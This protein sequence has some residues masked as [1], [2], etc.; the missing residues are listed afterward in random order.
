M[1]F[2]YKKYRLGVIRP[3]I[4]LKIAYGNKSI[5]QEVLVDSGAD[6]CLFDAE[7]GESIGIAIEQGERRV[8]AGVN[9]DLQTAYVHPITI[10]ISGWNYNIHAGF[11]RNFAPVYGIVGQ[12][13]FFHLFSVKFTYQKEEI[14]IKP[15]GE[16]HF[17]T[18]PPLT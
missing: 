13:G 18:P 12:H 9:A 10:N 11:V 8:F 17:S 7:V 1:K 2:K 6:L 15:V 3:I 5:V 16:K 14:E 4:P